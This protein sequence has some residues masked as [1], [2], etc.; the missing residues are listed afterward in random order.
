M[1][2]RGEHYGL[3]RK[4]PREAGSVPASPLAKHLAEDEKEFAETGSMGA[5]M[6]AKRRKIRD[7]FKADVNAEQDSSLFF[8]GVVVWI[9]GLTT[10][11]ANDLRTL[12]YK[13]GGE[14]GDRLTVV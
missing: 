13:H 11:P 12:L 1:S 8:K 4:R 14:V 6:Q 3:S 5:Y 7:Q 2:G 9:N 10:P